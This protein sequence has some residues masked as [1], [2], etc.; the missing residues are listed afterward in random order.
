ME[1]FTAFITFRPGSV[2]SMAQASAF[3]SV[4][5]S[6][7]NDFKLIKQLE[8]IIGLER[9]HR[10]VPVLGKCRVDLLPK[11]FVTQL[12]DDISSPAESF[13][14]IG[15]LFDA[16]NTLPAVEGGRFKGVVYFN[17]GLFAQPPGSNCANWKSSCSEKPRP[18]TGTKCNRKSL[19]RFSN[20]RWRKTS[21]ARRA[22]TG[23][24]S[25]H[26]QRL[27][28]CRRATDGGLHRG[29]TK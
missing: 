25:R 8:M 6:S 10:V 7:Q 4:G 23:H 13:D 20:T 22:R 16:M 9:S 1:A 17:G 29:L 2:V 19:A 26:S 11:Y 27:S 3:E 21:A 14:L 24:F 15:G 12:L 28:K 18:S 5:L